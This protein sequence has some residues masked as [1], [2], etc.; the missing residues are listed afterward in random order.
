MLFEFI[1]SYF[2]E[3]LIIIDGFDECLKKNVVISLLYERYFN[4]VD[5]KMFVV[6]LCVKFMRGYFLREFV[7]MIIFRFNE[8]D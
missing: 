4:S 8:L 1:V 5:E 7:F 3:V 2:E 6:V